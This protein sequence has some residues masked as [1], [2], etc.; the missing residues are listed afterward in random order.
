M[1]DPYVLATPVVRIPEIFSSHRQE[2]R[3]EYTTREGI[4]GRIG[5]RYLYSRDTQSEQGEK[6]KKSPCLPISRMQQGELNN[7]DATRIY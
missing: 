6:G 1:D 7:Q 5:A 3:P 2:G 4:A